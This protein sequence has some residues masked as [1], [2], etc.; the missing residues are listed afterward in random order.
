MTDVVLLG[1]LNLP[2]W[3]P[4][5][6]P[7]PHVACHVVQLQIIRRITADRTGAA[8]TLQCR[9]GEKVRARR[10]HVIAP[11]VARAFALAARQGLEERQLMNGRVNEDI[12]RLAEAPLGCKN[13]QGLSP[14]GCPET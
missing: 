3:I 11:R 13:P 1:F 5:C 2:V 6:N 8:M 4:I 10:V 14:P 12:G 9:V 7:L